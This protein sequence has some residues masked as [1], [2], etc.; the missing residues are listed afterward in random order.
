MRT[1]FILWNNS[2]QTFYLQSLQDDDLK[3]LGR[4]HDSHEAL[5]T[6]EEAR[7]LCPGRVSV[8][9]MFGR[10]KQTVESWEI[11]L[12]ELLRVCD[13]H[14]SLYQLTLERGT[15]LFKQVECSAVTMPSEDVTA[16]MYQRARKTLHQHGFQ[17]YEVSNFARHVSLCCN[18]TVL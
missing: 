4:D 1:F 13:D 12:S 15:Q 9:V 7:R 11:E 10:P 18:K 14:V 6:I 17:Q 5:Q 8:D 3:S 16:E 2:D